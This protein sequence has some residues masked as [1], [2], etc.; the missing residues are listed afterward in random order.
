MKE[1]LGPKVNAPSPCAVQQQLLAVGWDKATSSAPHA[2]VGPATYTKL[3]ATSD[4]SYGGDAAA[5]CEDCVCGFHVET[6]RQSQALCKPYPATI[7][8]IQ[9]RNMSDNIAMETV[10]TKWLLARMSG[11]RGE[12]ARL[13]EALG[14]KPDQVAKILNGVRRVQPDEIPRLMA[15][16]NEERQTLSEDEIR[17]LRLFREATESRQE[18]AVALLSAPPSK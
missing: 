6:L 18:A 7:A 3:A 4:G 5:D 2:G 16:F 14:I 8:I 17:L 11:R 10:D 1:M 12:K 13:A 15:F 9:G